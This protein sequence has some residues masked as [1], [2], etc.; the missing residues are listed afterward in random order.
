MTLR[1]PCAGAVALGLGLLVSSLAPS[2][3][4]SDVLAAPV[5][6]APDAGS[7][8]P[9]RILERLALEAGSERVTRA[10][11]SLGS[12]AGLTSAGLL[13][14]ADGDAGFGR[15]IWIA[16][17]L[18]V[19]G[20]VLTLFLASP[21]ERLERDAGRRSVGYSPAALERAWH[22]QAEETRS[23][24]TIISVV[25]FVIGGAGF[26]ASGAL[27]AGWGDWSE[28]TRERWAVELFAGGTLFTSAGIAQL[29]IRADVEEAYDLAYPAGAGS[30][31]QLH[32]APAHGGATLQLGGQF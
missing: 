28:R 20:G 14:E 22:E 9:A 10:W 3:L 16:G 7:D 23:A 24:R 2:A 29:L 17:L 12:G 26:A 21:L 30:G 5:L 15:V 13:D 1:L 11:L 25:N 4:A 19:T 8:E 18:S 6:A 32:F 27:A 31:L